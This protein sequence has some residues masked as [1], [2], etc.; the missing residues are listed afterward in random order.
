M[1]FGRLRAAEIAIAALSLAL[2]AD[3]FAVGW[4]D[5]AAA[6]IGHV[7]TFILA[8]VGLTCFLQTLLRR[9][10]TGGIASA[11]ALTILAP[12]T[13]IVLLVALVSAGSSSG[14]EGSGGP[15]I[16]LAIAGSALMLAFAVWSLRDESR[17]FSPE[18]GPTV[19]AVELPESRGAAA[20]G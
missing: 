9:V 14:V 15:G 17:G 8:G 18:P 2:L 4:A 6:G 5:G 13:L 1:R 20:D 7:M 3:A 16:E 19:S 11:V 10:P 12:L